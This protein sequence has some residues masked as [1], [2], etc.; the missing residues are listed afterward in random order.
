MTRALLM[1][2]LRVVTVGGAATAVDTLVLAALYY[3]YGLGA[4]TAALCGSLVGGAVNFVLNRTWVF[5]AT[6]GAWWRQALLYATLV[7]GGGALVGAVVVSTLHSFGIPVLLAKCGSIG[8]VLVAW[9]Y[10]MS[11]RVVFRDAARQ[12]SA[13]SRPQLIARNR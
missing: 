5:G 2:M 7:V 12:R 10:P 13:G 9:T 6:A 1:R 8:I 11:A 4:G 3:G